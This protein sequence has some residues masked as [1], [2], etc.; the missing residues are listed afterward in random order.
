MCIYIYIHYI[1]NTYSDLFPFNVDAAKRALAS[2]VAAAPW[3]ATVVRPSAVS[4]GASTLETYL[5]IYCFRHTYIYICMYMYM[6]VCVH[7]F[8]ST[9]IFV[10]IVLSVYY[11]FICLFIHAIMMSYTQIYNTYIYIAILEWIEYEQV[12][13]HWE[14]E[15]LWKFHILSTSG[16][17]HILHLYIH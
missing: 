1:A 13:P 7:L 12:N 5:F 16:W 14:W 10:C 4:N 17:L 3:D 11:W 15:Y 6:C 9:F 8:I 2:Q